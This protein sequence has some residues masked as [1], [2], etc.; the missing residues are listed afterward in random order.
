MLLDVPARKIDGQI[1][2][3]GYQ[4]HTVA[5]IARMVKDVVEQEMPHLRPIEVATTPSNDLRSYH[6]SSDKITRVL[7]YRPK[8]TIEDAVR[9]LCAAFR[10][11]KVPGSLDDDRYYNVKR[12]KRTRAA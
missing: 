5:E 11:G 2:N 1:F 3:A 7:G 10:A 8:R 12:L 9:D 6:I 4:N